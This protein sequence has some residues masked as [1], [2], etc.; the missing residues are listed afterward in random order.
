[1]CGGARKIILFN[2][3]PEQFCV[4]NPTYSRHFRRLLSLPSDVRFPIARCQECAFVYAGLLPSG[5]FLAEVYDKVICFEACIEESGRP[6]DCARRMNYLAT[7]LLLAPSEP[8]LKALDFGCGLGLTSRLLAPA[9]GSVVG[10]EP[11]PAR[12]A[13]LRRAGCTAITTQEELSNHSPFGAVICDNVLEHLPDPLQTLRLIA[14][15]CKPGS[16]V[17]IGVPEC[18]ERFIRK[19]A[20]AISNGRTIDKT[21]NPWEHLNYFS[22]GHLDS[23]ARKAGLDPLT[24]WDLPG[25]VNIGLRPER[26]FL[27]RLKNGIASGARL[28]RYTAA[29]LQVRGTDT[30]HRVKT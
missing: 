16:V 11:S 29:G 8:P 30:F 2:L 27:S 6:E 3:E 24:G 18:D 13:F 19:Q 14:S 28:L 15:L 17:F 10:F 25:N 4:V 26:R 1:M 5:P 22:V 7:L 20:K 21:L 9:A 12:L 23:L